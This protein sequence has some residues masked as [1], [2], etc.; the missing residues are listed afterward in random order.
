MNLND[1]HSA[2]KSV[3]AKVLST[4]GESTVVS[5][6][7]AAGETLKEHSSK[8]AAILLCIDGEATYS[9]TPE[10]ATQLSAGIYVDIVPDVKHAV[11]AQTDTRLLLIK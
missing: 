6:H 7:I 9:E 5:I 10:T 3:S 2:G 8:V 4:H 1:L 11:T